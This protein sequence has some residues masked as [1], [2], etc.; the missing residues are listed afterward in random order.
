MGCFDNEIVSDLVKY[1]NISKVQEFQLARRLVYAYG[2]SIDIAETIV[3]YW[4][5]AF[6]INFNEERI[7]EKSPIIVRISDVNDDTNF[8]G[9]V[10]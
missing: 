1:K 10:W 2:C 6:G 4:I 5:E 3:Q 8:D 7:G 9:C